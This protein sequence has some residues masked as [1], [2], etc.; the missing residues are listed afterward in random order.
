MLQDELSKF[1]I[2]IKKGVQKYEGLGA[3]DDTVMALAFA[4]EAAIRGNVFSF[5]FM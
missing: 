3:H 4:T 5:V 2:A 1:G